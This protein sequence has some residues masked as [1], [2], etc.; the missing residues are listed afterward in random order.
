MS[1][2]AKI[3]NKKITKKKM[4]FN[5]NDILKVIKK[6]FNKIKSDYFILTFFVVSNFINVYKRK[7]EEC[8]L[9]NIFFYYGS[10]MCNKFDIL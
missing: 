3:K 8:L 7:R 10:T 6:I 5:K 1:N 2:K 9:C 4:I